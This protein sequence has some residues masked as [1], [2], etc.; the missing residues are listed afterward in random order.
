M[1]TISN[2]LSEPLT[3]MIEARAIKRKYMRIKS[4][5]SSL[6]N[7]FFNSKRIAISG[8][9]TLYD[10]RSLI[11]HLHNSGAI[12]EREINPRTD[13]FIAGKEPNENKI[14]K[15]LR[16]PKLKILF[17]KDLMDFYILDEATRNAYRELV[18]YNSNKA[19]KLV[20][21]IHELIKSEEF[22][23]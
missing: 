11:E 5:G 7:S 17:E 14:S 2:I 22:S 18:E 19:A 10:R 1:G 21:I 20:N 6:N 15:A 3:E 4:N 9:F 23:H 16:S 13:F 8:S 12:I